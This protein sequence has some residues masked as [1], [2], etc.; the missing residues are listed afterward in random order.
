MPY[1]IALDLRDL[2]DTHALSSDD[3]L[4]GVAEQTCVWNREGH[5]WD[6]D[7]HYVRCYDSRFNVYPSVDDS[8]LE[9][10]EPLSDIVLAA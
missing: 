9:D 10:Y 3:V 4:E 6:E 5:R 2:A 7:C 1:A 8:D